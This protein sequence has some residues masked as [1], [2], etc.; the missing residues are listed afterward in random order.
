MGPNGAGKSTL[1]KVIAGKLD[2]DVGKVTFGDRVDVGYYAQEHESLDTARTVLEEIRSVR[3]LNR[4]RARSI[5]SHCLFQGDRVATRVGSLSLGERSRLALAK[6]VASG[7]NLLLLDE[8]TNHLDVF[9]REQVKMALREYEGTVLIIS[10]DSDFLEG[11]G[12]EQVLLLPEHK[13]GLL[14]QI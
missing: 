11:I 12:V 14:G 4:S 13:F 7:H 6:L 8:P 10:H 9:A 3:G 2:P 5:L 1:L